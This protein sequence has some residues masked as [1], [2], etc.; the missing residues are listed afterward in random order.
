MQQSPSHTSQATTQCQL[1]LG[2]PSS[3]LTYKR[4]PLQSL[5]RSQR[6]SPPLWYALMPDVP[7][8]ETSTRKV[9]IQVFTPGATGELLRVLRFVAARSAPATWSCSCTSGPCLPAQCS[10]L[11]TLSWVCWTSFCELGAATDGE[12]VQ[13]H[14]KDSTLCGQTW[15]TERDRAARETGRL[16]ELR[17]PHARS[18]SPCVLP[19]PGGK[20]P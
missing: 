1:A 14:D 2:I 18:P 16:A 20:P 7:A 13:Y 6:R 5:S 10:S 15:P 9:A 11:S 4:S 8:W 3:R 19:P 17:L 12:A